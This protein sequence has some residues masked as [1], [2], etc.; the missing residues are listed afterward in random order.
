MK[1]TISYILG[2]EQVDKYLQGIEL[3]DVEKSINIKIYSFNSK[4]EL[5]AFEKGMQEAVGWTEVFQNQLNI[6]EARTIENKGD[7][8]N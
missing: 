6:V 4:S 5:L 1:Y 8:F 3:S 7:G 2:K